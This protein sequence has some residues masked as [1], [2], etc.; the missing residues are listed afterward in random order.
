MEITLEEFQEAANRRTVAPG[1]RPQP[2]SVA[3]REFAVQYARREMAAGSSKSAILRTL[4]ISDGAL[5]KWMSPKDAGT[6]RGFR[7]VRLKKDA[8]SQSGL[9][10]LTPDG[11]RVEGLTPGSAA[12]LLKAL[13]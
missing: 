2:Y 1:V 7:R 13:G 4:G 12:A 10:I 11:Y 6:G 5:T 9:T 3:E 8:G